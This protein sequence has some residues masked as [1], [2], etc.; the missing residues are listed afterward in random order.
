MKMLSV[1]IELEVDEKEIEL[2]KPLWDEIIKSIES[3]KA[4]ITK[5]SIFQSSDEW[6]TFLSHS[7]DF[8]SIEKAK[9]LAKQNKMWWK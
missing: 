4:K 9:E 2:H 8:S 6:E 3:K 1:R 5:I 7:S